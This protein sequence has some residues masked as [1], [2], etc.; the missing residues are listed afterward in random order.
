M[1]LSR[2]ISRNA[3]LSFLDEIYNTDNVQI[4]HSDRTMESEA[5]TT[6][7]KYHDQDYSVAD[8]VS[9]VVM[10]REELKRVFTFD[11]H[12]KIVRFSAEP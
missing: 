7:R 11:K 8:A 6:I 4:F 12:F 9:F 1:L 3:A 5:Y 2:R 10:K